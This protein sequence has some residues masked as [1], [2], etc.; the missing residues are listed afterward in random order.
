[1][2]L[3]KML[4]QVECIYEL[5]S[6]KREKIPYRKR[7]KKQPITGLGAQ[8]AQIMDK[9]SK[10]GISAVSAARLNNHFKPE[11][12]A[13]GLSLPLNHLLMS[14]KPRKEK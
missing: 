11:R 14:S 2:L 12:P 3:G 9:Q 8:P 7:Q 4:A 5:K 6:S 1:M 10:P 13:L